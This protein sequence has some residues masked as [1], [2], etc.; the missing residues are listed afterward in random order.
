MLP[1]GLSSAPYIFT[2]TLKPL[3]KSWRSQGI[4]IAIFLD[5]GL[6]GGTDFFSAKVNSLVVHSDLL[7]SG[8][9][10]NEVKSLWEPVQVITWLCVVLDTTDG[11]IKATDERI[12]KLNAGLVEL[13]S[14]QPPQKVH[15]KRVATV[16]GQI[17]SLSP[18]VGYVARI[19]T[20]FLFS[21][22]NSARS[23]ESEVFSQTTLFQ[24]SVSGRTTW[25]S[26]IARFVGRSSPSQGHLF[27]C[28]QFGFWCFRKELEFSISSELVSC[29]AYPKFHLKHS[30]LFA[31]PW[32][33]SRVIF[34]C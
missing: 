18:C 19:M 31:S 20:R 15:V 33:L 28:L 32:K 8:F 3:Q 12:E 10:P 5:D 27:R 4:P 17:T 24:K 30:K 22:V 2:S 29:R 25:Y 14:C 6:G 21:V 7:K 23:W 11:T 34:W 1:F 13:L 9:V 16:T 26:S